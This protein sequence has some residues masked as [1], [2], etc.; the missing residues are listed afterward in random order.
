MLTFANQVLPPPSRQT[1]HLALKYSYIKIGMAILVIAFISSCKTNIPITSEATNT[2]LNEVTTSIDIDSELVL[3]FE[4]SNSALQDSLDGLI[5]ASITGPIIFSDRLIKVYLQRAHATTISFDDRKLLVEVPMQ[6]E[7]IKEVFTKDITASGELLLTFIGDIDITNDWQLATKT[8]LID[9]NWTQR[10]VMNLGLFGIP[11]E[12][13]SNSIVKRL[14]DDVEASIDEAI[15][16]NFNLQSQI[17]SLA[18]HITTPINLD[19]IGAGTAQLIVDTV[20]MTGLSSDDKY[21]YGKVIISNNIRVANSVSKINAEALPVFKWWKS[22]TDTSSIGIDA[23]ISFEFLNKILSKQVIGRRFEHGDNFLIIDDISL[24]GAPGQIRA[25]CKTSGSFEGYVTISG[26]PVIQTNKTAIS[27]INV[28]VSLD[29]DNV[30]KQALIWIVK[31]KIKE[32]LASMLN[33]ELSD[34]FGLVKSSLDYQ[35]NSIAPDSKVSSDM[36]IEYFSFNHLQVGR[37]GL[38][39]TLNARF[40]VTVVLDEF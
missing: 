30:F 16:S 3:N 1:I 37:D 21:S 13:I 35:I 10:P 29:S 6:I 8:E 34:Y 17:K 18:A 2:E 12:S 32:S 28:E 27:A 25:R 9:H 31:G 15:S 11:I 26:E 39:G 23:L 7:V 38:Y 5:D 33:I 19:T 22:N 36:K 40:I 24:S 20:K 4:I 14:T